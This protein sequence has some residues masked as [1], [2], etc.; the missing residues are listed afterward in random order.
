MT[1]IVIAFTTFLI[2]IN[3]FL[4][5]L[6]GNKSSIIDSSSTVNDSQVLGINNQESVIE[7]IGTNIIQSSYLNPEFQDYRAYIL[8]KYFESYNSPLKG[9][10]SDFIVACDKYGLSKD[11]SVI[12]AIAFTETRLCTQ[13]LS[14][15]QFNCWGFGGSHENRIIFNNFTESIEYV[16][17]TL[18]KGYGNSLFDPEGIAAVYCGANCTTWGLSVNQQRDAIERLSVS[19]NLP[20]IRK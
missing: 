1:K 9:Y 13:A 15:K 7:P 17:R 16:T 18:S 8:D 19:L 5:I 14:A 10:G 20:S 12:P 6:G 4:S 2:L 3:L 11:C